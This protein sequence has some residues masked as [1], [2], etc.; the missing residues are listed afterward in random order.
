MV[1]N[2]IVGTGYYNKWCYI[3]PNE[4]SL[5]AFT[6]KGGKPLRVPIAHAE[7]RFVFDKD[8]EKEILHNNLI[9]ISIVI[10][11]GCFQKTSP[12]TLTG[13]CF[14]RPH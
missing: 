7:G 1:G 2:R 9:H 14:L 4:D 5:S 6:K 11:A 13:L 10:A 8:L 3:K 12:Q